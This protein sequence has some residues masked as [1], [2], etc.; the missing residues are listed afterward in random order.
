MALQLL[1]PVIAFSFC[2]RWH[3][4][5]V[6]LCPLIFATT[7]KRP[8]WRRDTS[9]NDT[10]PNKIHLNIR[11]LAWMAAGKYQISSPD[12]RTFGLPPPFCDETLVCSRAHFF[13]LA[14]QTWR[15]DERW[16][17]GRRQERRGT[18]VAHSLGFYTEAKAHEIKDDHP[19]VRNRA[20]LAYFGPLWVPIETCYKAYASCQSE[21]PRALWDH[22]WNM[23]NGVQGGHKGRQA[24]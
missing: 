10:H 15:T 21:Q 5:T 4:K 22:W 23:D 17:E 14:P 2:I 7:L 9:L 3:F 24:T 11:T 16:S 12:S 13:W 1:N 19:A 20:L 8:I 18:E 6:V